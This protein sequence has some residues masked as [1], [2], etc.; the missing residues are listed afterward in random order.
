MEVHEEGGKVGRV[1]EVFGDVGH[2]LGGE[3]VGSKDVGDDGC[4]GIEIGESLFA[5]FF[6]CCAV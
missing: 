4:G 3:V 6:E 2:D 1:D 5:S